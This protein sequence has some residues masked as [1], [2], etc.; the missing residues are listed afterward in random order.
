VKDGK[1]AGMISI[2]DIVKAIITEQKNMIQNL[3]D[4]MQGSGYA[5]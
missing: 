3:E 4:Y 5:R 2:G 1:L